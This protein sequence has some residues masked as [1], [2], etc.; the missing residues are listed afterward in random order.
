MVLRPDRRGTWPNS[1]RYPF[2]RRRKP[3]N[4][5]DFGAMWPE[6]AGTWQRFHD[7]SHARSAKD[8]EKNENLCDAFALVG[9]SAIDR[10]RG[11]DQR[12]SCDRIESWRL[13]RDPG[14][15]RIGIADLRANS[16]RHHDYP[17]KFGSPRMGRF[18]PEIMG[19]SRVF[20]DAIRSCDFGIASLV[21]SNDCREVSRFF[22]NS[23]C[24]KSV[25]LWTDNS[26]FCKKQ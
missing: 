17:G 18:D 16:A 8:L 24:G 11:N 21:Y 19:R 6:F 20:R 26:R 10:D 15:E 22:R 14:L 23:H 5:I 7:E 13:A 25:R 2:A 12:N 4:R 3:G 9:K 1:T